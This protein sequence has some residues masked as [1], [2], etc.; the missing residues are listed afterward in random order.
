MPIKLLALDI[1]GTLLNSQRQVTRRTSEAIKLAVEKGLQV[2]LVTGRRFHAARPV[3]IELG[4]ELPLVTH[5]G[6][7][8]KD[9]KT[10]QILDY[11]PLDATIARELVEIGRHL[12]AD[13]LC[14]DEPEGEV[15]LLFETVSEKNQR[16]Q[17][18]IEAFGE[19]AEKVADLS[20]YIQDSIIQIFYSG[21]CSLM[22]TVT[23]KIEQELGDK[24]KLVQTVYQKS[25]MTIVDVINPNCSKATGVEFIAHRLGIGR[26]EV[27]AVGDNL[28][29]LDML[30]YAGFPVIMA[31]AEA[32]L[33]EF[34]YQTTLSN[35]ED[36]VAEVI[37]RYILSD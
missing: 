1:D 31:N 23:D 25:D 30:Q 18:Y 16:L 26:Q 28:N 10:L 13:T 4:L 15:K 21:H 5:N 37:E 36:G 20:S 7:L 2:V 8:T 6:A 9:T 33:K 24:I 17:R 35:D 34:G 14:C 3:A 29:D 11:H 27:M 12:G 22:Q 32:R 19:Y